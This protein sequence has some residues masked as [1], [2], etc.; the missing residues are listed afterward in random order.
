MLTV[1]WEARCPYGAYFDRVPNAVFFLGLSSDPD[2][3]DDDIILHEM[4]H[5]VA[6]NFS[7]DDTLGGD[8]VIVDQLDPRTS[9][10]EGLAHYWSAAVRRH[11]NLRLSALPG[12]PP[13]EYAAPNLQ[14]DNKG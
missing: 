4:G 9:W 8:H 6:F 11:E 3:F 2:E 5:W 12:P 14:V 7:R 1:D 13:P 10:S